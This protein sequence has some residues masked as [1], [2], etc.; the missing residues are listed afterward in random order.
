MLYS[1]PL[2]VLGI[3]DLLVEGMVVLKGHPGHWRTDAAESPGGGGGLRG[4]FDIHVVSHQLRL[5]NGQLSVP[6]YMLRYYD[7]T[8][9]QSG[10]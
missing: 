5:Q 10:A 2:R 6:H 4:V 3:V 9:T 1:L 7:D 8:I